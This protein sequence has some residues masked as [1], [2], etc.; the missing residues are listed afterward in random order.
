MKLSKI[1]KKE[2]SRYLEIYDFT[3]YLKDKNILITGSSGMTASG[4][5][6]WILFENEIH[7]TNCHIYASTRHPEDKF[8]YIEE[9]DNITM[10]LFGHEEEKI[11]EN[12]IDYII[13]AAAPT[14]RNFFITKPVETMRVIIDETEKMLDL[15]KEKSSNMIFLSSVE[16]YGVPNENEPLKENYV[17]AVDSLNI[18]SGYP[19][20]KKAAEFLCYA[21]N[22]EYDVDVKI[23]RPSSI[24]GLL[25]SYDEQRVFAEILRCVIENKNLIMKSD[26]LSKKSFIYTLDAI[27]AILT[28]LFKGQAGECYN[29]TDP[30]TFLTVKD[31]AELVFKKFNPKLSIEYK[32]ENSSKTG[33]LPHLEFTQNIE[34]IK[35]LDWEPITKLEDIYKI[36]IERFNEVKI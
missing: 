13:Q 36:D 29:I 10:C 9:N 21:M 15:A 6:K 1:E 30:S 14:G 3:K 12:K 27:S 25:Q 5:I 16:A 17:G 18:R 32:I 34:K 4:I 35:E 26:G 28:V 19:M 20:G 24:Q 8:D 23:V 11:G 7:N 31:L 33:Y 2:F 22:K